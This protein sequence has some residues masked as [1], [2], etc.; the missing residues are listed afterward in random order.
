M[1]EAG[2]R[3]GVSP[4]GRSPAGSV[5]ELKEWVREAE[6]LGFDFIA[7]GDHLGGPAPFAVLTAVA[8]ASER[9][10]VRTY[11][12]NVAFWNPALLARE[13]ATLDRLSGGRVELG[14]GAGALRAE[15]EAAGLRWRP[16]AER[17][18]HLEQT[19]QLVRRALADPDHSP[20]PVQAP[21][22]VLVGAMSRAGLAVAA[23]HAEIVGFAGV[24]QA[25]GKPAGTLRAATAEETDELVEW[26]RQR[27]SG[28][29]YESDVLLQAVEL[30]RDPLSAAKTFIEREGEEEDPHVLAESPCVLFAVTAA[31]AAAEIEQRRERWGFTSFTT[32]GPSMAALAQ[33][34]Q[35]LA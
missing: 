33:V 35:E 20:P 21:V 5:A 18:Q 19:L 27:A 29:N 12:L 13:A 34:R 4:S 32:F 1:S 15:F 14:L 8:A 28:R 30:G 24:R 3:F 9:L 6:E 25:E 26:V 22:P 31:E 10:R 2:Y 23:E 7:K 17:V 16:A 11:V